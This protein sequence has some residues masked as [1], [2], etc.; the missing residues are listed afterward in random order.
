MKV[1]WYCRACKNTYEEVHLEGRK[2]KFIDAMEEARKDSSG[3]PWR[4]VLFCPTCDTVVGEVHFPSLTASPLLVD[5]NVVI[6]FSFTPL[7]EE[8]ATVVREIPVPV[9]EGKAEG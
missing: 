7:T 9:E 3:K 8:E 6:S 2:V 1:N 4:V 5:G